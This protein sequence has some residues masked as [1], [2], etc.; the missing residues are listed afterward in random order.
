MLVDL[1]PWTVAAL[2]VFRE[3]VWF[4]VATVLAVTFVGAAGTVPGALRFFGGAGAASLGSGFTKKLDMPGI[5]SLGVV[6]LLAF[7]AVGKTAVVRERLRVFTPELS[8]SSL[9][10]LVEEV[11]VEEPRAFFDAG[12]QS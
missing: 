3:P 4:V 10:R 5:W 11:E 2:A 8:G 6:E 1:E 7:D 9:C 12:A